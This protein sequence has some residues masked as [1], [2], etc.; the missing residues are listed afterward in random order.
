MHRA[1]NIVAIG[2]LALA[3]CG[4][5]TS[6]GTG[7][8]QST[9]AS[10]GGAGTT[11]AQACADIALATC[12]KRN[13]CSMNGF[14]N[15][16]VYGSEATCEAEAALTCPSSITAKGSAQTP[17]HIEQCINAFAGYAC[18][19]FW[20]S[21][22]PAAC[23]P[24]AGS[25]ANGAACG[26]SGQCTSTFCAVGPFA[27][28]GTCQPLPLPGAACQVQADCGRGFACVKPAG[29]TVQTK[30]K[31]AAFA[32]MGEP[33]LTGSTPCQATLS[34][35][36]D[37]PTTSTLGT[38]VAAGATINAPCDTTRKTA[39]ACDFT[40]GLACI[41]SNTKNGAGKCLPIELAAA[42]QPCGDLPGG[43]GAAFLFTISASCQGGGLCKRSAPASATFVCVAPAAD[44]MPCD[45]DET[46]GPPCLSPAKCVPKKGAP[47]GTTAGTCTVPD[48]TTCL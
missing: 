34:C 46:K 47:A 1:S 28:C 16:V 29:A 10:M 39:P 40:L 17:A 22:P 35:Q 7:G 48:A 5:G 45:S 33:C 6:T 26:A 44:G 41:P 13:A 30:G 25:L 23:T 12:I 15:D 11:V 31:C 4:G 18:P 42:G 36:G 32:A 27:T 3:A 37:D 38:C 14:E 8:S 43:A 9:G 20:D 21:N 2:A 24:P 19:D